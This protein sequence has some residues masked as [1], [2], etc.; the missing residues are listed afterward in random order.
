MPDRTITEY[1]DELDAAR[2]EAAKI[3]DTIEAKE[4]ELKD[5]RKSLGALINPPFAGQPAGKIWY[6]EHELNRKNKEV[7]VR[8]IDRLWQQG[9]EQDRNKQYPLIHL[10]V[11]E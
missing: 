2:K 9:P 3:R 8:Q 1:L 6:L 7:M 10:Q 11:K 5:L 4:F